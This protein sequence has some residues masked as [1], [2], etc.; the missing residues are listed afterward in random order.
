MAKRGWLGEIPSH[1]G[2][3][4]KGNGRMGW[5]GGGIY[6]HVRLDRKRYERWGRTPLLVTS[7]GQVIADVLGIF[8]QPVS[9]W[10]KTLAL[11]NGSQHSPPLH[12]LISLPLTSP[13]LPDFS[14]SHIPYAT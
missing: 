1:G 12:Y 3:M 14:T 7:P 9:L 8:P 5:G 13:T 6:H 2:L 4:T 11:Q 10:Q